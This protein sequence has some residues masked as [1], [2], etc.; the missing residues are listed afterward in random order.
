MTNHSHRIREEAKL[1]ALFI[2]AI[3]L[4]YFADRLL[5]LENLGL[6]PR[7]LS[8]TLGIITMPFLHADWQHITSNT[9]PLIVLLALLAGSRAD[10]IKVVIF[11]SLI[12]GALLWLFG[13]SNSIH[14]GASLLVF[15]LGVF[16]VVSGML[17]KR[18]LPI[19]VS[20]IVVALYGSTMLTGVLPWQKG[21]SWEGHLFGSLAGGIVAWILTRTNNKG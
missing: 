19:I 8:G 16:L 14:I 11:I 6:A 12:G 15:G 9:L 2:A 10:S 21:V 5:P 13:R 4:I 1:I 20:L 3:W 18:T 17:E 7:E